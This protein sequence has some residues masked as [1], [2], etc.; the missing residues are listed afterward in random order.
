MKLNAFVSSSVSAVRDFV[1]REDDRPYISLVIYNHRFN[2]LLDSGSSISILGSDLSDLF[3]SLGASLHGCRDITYIATANDSQAKVK[4][5]LSLPV[6]VRNLTRVIKFYVIPDV[7]TPLILGVDFWKAFNIAPNLFK[8]FSVNKHVTTR[9]FVS[10]VRLHSFDQLHPDQR[11]IADSMIRNF[12]SISFERKGLGRTELLVHTIDTGDCKPIK[13]RYYPI[14]PHR[15]VELNRQLDEMLEQDVVETS[16]SAWNNPTLFTPKSNGELRFCLDSRKLN[17]VSKHDAYPLPYVSGILDQLRDARFLSSIDLKSAFWQIPLDE[18]SKERT[19][20]TVPGRGLFQFKV[21]CFG[22]TGAPATQQR[23]MDKL[24]GPEFNGRLFVY[25]DDI[26]VV[27][28]TFDDHISLLNRVLDRLKSANLTINYGKSKFFRSELKYLGYVVD[29]RGLRTDPSKIQSIVDYP[30]PCN[31]KEVKMFLGTASYYRRFIQNF[32]DIAAPLNALTSTRKNAPPFVWSDDADKSFQ[33]LKSALVSAPILSCPDFSKPFAVHCDA[34]GYGVGGTLTQ[35]AADG[36][37]HPIAF[38]SRSLNKAERNYSATEREALAVVFSIEHFRPYLE[39]GQ[40]FRVV[41]DHSSLKWFFNLTNPTGRLARWGCRLSPYDF[42]IVHRKGK[43]H[44]VPDA[45]SRAVPVLETHSCDWY[46]KLFQKCEQFPT[47]CPNFIINDSKLYRYSKNKFNFSNEFDWK[48]VVPSDRR[49]ELLQSCHCDELVHLGTFKTYK[50][51]SQNYYWPDLYQDVVNFIKNCDVCSAY[52]HSQK[53]PAGLMGNPKV[54][55]RPFESISMDLVGPLPRSRAGYTYIFTVVCCFS[56]FVLLFPLRRAVGKTIAQ[57]L[58][59][60]VFLKHGIPRTIIADHGAQ[61]TGK[62]LNALFARYDIPQIHLI[63]RH[64]PQVSTV[65]RYHRTLM[66]AVSILV[67]Q[68]HRSWDT[69]L[70]KVQFALN[71]TVNESTRFTPFFLVHGR[72]A[73]PCGKVYVS[74]RTSQLDLS[75]DS[76]EDYATKLG[77]LR[78]VFDRVLSTLAKSHERNARNYNKGRRSNEYEVGDVVWKKTFPQSD[79]SKFFMAKLAPRYEK[80]RVLCKHSPLV[81]ELE[82]VVTGKN[83]GFWH[84]QHLKGD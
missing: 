61:F 69:T 80:C 73:I 67:Q 36:Q 47:S 24:F 11:V 68:D 78:G 25:L 28:K 48:E 40:R 76:P 84:I 44:V 60:E 22:L 64:C 6:K 19:A 16:T 58:E 5:Y 3:L 18:Q 15:L 2:G 72:E 81:Y 10:E 54:C 31:R 45:L 75:G 34:S 53:P 37:E 63:P 66:T 27:S 82:S 12:E 32:S 4:G 62:E 39:G 79:A 46:N 51:L 23:L 20:F 70:P 21:M 52:K 83:L 56:K 13:Q 1:D 77:G 49:S 17:S 26:I 74:Q 7:T 30:T 33:K 35:T 29:E 41:T 43:E 14:S 71:T 55:S 59:D 8:D 9:N 50:R 42:E 57:R 38:A 65:E